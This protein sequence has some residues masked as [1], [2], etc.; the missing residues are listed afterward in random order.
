MTTAAMGSQWQ[1]EE[2]GLYDAP[3][4][5]FT[6]TGAPVNQCVEF[7]ASTRDSNHLVLSSKAG[8]GG[9][10]SVEQCGNPL[11]P[12]TH[13]PYN[14]GYSEPP[15]FQLTRNLKASDTEMNDVGTFILDVLS[16]HELEFYWYSS[17]SHS[18]SKYSVA[19]SGHEL[20]CL[21]L[22]KKNIKD[23][24]YLCCCCIHSEKWAFQYVNFQSGTKMLW[25]GPL[26]S[27]C[28]INRV[29]ALH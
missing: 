21:R 22:E 23:G 4:S 18:P 27:T 24:N 9:S 7:T 1:C 11:A 20:K 26:L 12:T 19:M 2:K 3:F 13:S 25:S 8:H 17:F 5:D 28:Y 29:H 6:A 16:A 14:L 15:H 10:T